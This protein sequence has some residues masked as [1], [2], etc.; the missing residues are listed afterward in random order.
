ME[1]ATVNDLKKNK[2]H[3]LT[4]KERMIIKYDELLIL[5]DR[6]EKGRNKVWKPGNKENS[7][8]YKDF[9]IMNNYTNNIKENKEYEM[10]WKK[11]RIKPRSK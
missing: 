6:K 7:F 1:L 5:N 11:R 2:R 4:K 3:T 8:M 10:N 9:L